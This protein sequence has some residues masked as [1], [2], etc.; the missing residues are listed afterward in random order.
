M[1]DQYPLTALP[2][3]YEGSEEVAALD[4]LPHE[5]DQK[6]DETQGAE[7]IDIQIADALFTA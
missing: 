4:A 7:A 2:L 1:L 5:G 3:P 6:M